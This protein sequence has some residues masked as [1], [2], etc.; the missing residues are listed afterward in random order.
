[1]PFGYHGCFL[2]IDA[3]SG[4]A[5]RVPLSEAVLRAYLGGR[6]LGTR[7]LLDAGAPETDPLSPEAGQLIAGTV[8]KGLAK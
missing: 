7:V 2:R 8:G 4:H 5:E 3:G 6:G 1:M